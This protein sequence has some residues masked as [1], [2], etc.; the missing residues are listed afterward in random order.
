MEGTDSAPEKV[1]RQIMRRIDVGDIAVGGKLPSES[2]LCREYG[3]SRVT[4]RA[5]LQRLQA[6]GLITAR[7]G[8]GTYLQSK[9]YP[10][11]R[12]DTLAGGQPLCPAALLEMCEFRRDMDS[13][14]AEYAAQRATEEDIA[15]LDAIIEKMTGPLE[16]GDGREY[17]ECD[18]ALHV[19]IGAAS[20]NSYIR[21]TLEI[22]SDM[23]MRHVAESNRLLGMEHGFAQHRSIVDAI[24]KGNVKAA[25]FYAGEH[26]DVSRDLWMEML[27]SEKGGAERQ[28]RRGATGSRRR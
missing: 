7:P 15:A 21:R 2:L 27:R 11:L 5:A 24:R 20:G 16:R 25:A 13:L 4:V 18:R 3:V 6:L 8:G 9:P 14:A 26:A 19:R 23:I 10:I 1:F 12:L 28:I 22:T 17:S